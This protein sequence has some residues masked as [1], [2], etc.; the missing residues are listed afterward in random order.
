M[1]LLIINFEYPPLG[2][3]G[4][5]ATQHIAEE[6]AQRHEVH[7]ITT[8]H[9]SLM[10]TETLRGVHV[11]RVPVLGRRDLPTSTLLSLLSFAPTAFWCGLQ[12]TRRQQFDVINAQFVIPS[13]IPAALIARIRRRPL[14]VS[15]IGGDVYDPT[16]GT[17]PHR[18]G[19]LR[20]LIRRIARQ[21]SLCTAISEDAKQRALEL[22]H[23][24]CDI[25]VTHLGL[26]PQTTTATT[27]QALRAPTA[28]SLWVS[29]GRLI[30]RKGYRELLHAWQALPTAHLIVIGSGPLQDSL[31]RTAHELNLEDRVDFRGFVSETE[32]AQLLTVADGYVSAAE[33]EGFGLVF[34]EAM[35]AGLPI[36][37][38]NNG[39]QTDFLHHET[40]ALLVPPHNPAALSQAITRLMSDAALAHHLGANNKRDVQQFYLPA[41]VARF[42]AVLLR[43]QAI[44]ASSRTL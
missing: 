29:I 30:P 34:L 11:H 44:A 7:V 23:V 33:H 43:A 39:G 38:T 20:W 35:H 40:N 13:G 10:S 4:G 42:E 32:K 36:V 19:V 27:R 18:H 37:A 14:V 9:T 1:R 3:G 31:Q 2:G 22:H 6:L 41:T 28:K 15:F 12:L 24:K 8:K 26:K 16:K 21:A 17:S 25:T 5:V